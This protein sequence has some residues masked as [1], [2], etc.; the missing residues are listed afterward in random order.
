[1]TKVTVELPEAVQQRIAALAA[2][3]GF[4]L[5][6][7]IAV[8]AMEKLA[9]LRTV[10]Y[11]RAEAARGRRA[12]FESYLAAVPHGPVDAVDRMPE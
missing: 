6:Q 7:F 2:L 9:S 10:E 8:A 11:L 12:D 1:M 5:E 3:H 4:S